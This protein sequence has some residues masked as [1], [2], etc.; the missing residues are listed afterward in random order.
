MDPLKISSPAFRSGEFIPGKFTCQGQDVNPPI[1]IEGI[2]QETKSLALI[3]DD[4]D[5]PGGTWVHWV[6]WNIPMIES[7]SENSVPGEEGWNDFRRTGW[8]GPCPPSGAH[9]YFF[10][11]FA[12]DTTLKLPTTTTKRQLEDAMKGHV[13]AKGELIGKYKKL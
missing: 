12:L 8:G 1:Q 6:V 2:P 11:V 9:R 13:L 3:V 5:A 10:K 7:I 4:P